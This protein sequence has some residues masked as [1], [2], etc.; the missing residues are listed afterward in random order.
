MSCF[1]HDLEEVSSH[2]ATACSEESMTGW[3]SWSQEKSLLASVVT[4]VKVHRAS[5]GEDEPDARECK[6]RY[7]E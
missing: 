7:L 5:P 3:R 1:D 2:W 4:I 6:D